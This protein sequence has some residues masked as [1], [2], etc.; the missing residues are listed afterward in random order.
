MLVSWPG[1]RVDFCE[2]GSVSSNNS[3][4]KDVLAH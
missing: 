1:C 2:W 4:A 3:V